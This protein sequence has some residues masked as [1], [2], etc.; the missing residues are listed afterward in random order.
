[1]PDARELALSLSLR[2]VWVMEIQLSL[3]VLEHKRNMRTLA[4]I[5]A[6]ANSKGLPGKNIRTFCGKP[7]LSWSIKAA[8]DCP[9]IDEVCVSSDGPEIL[10][11]AERASA[12][13]IKRPDHL[14]SDT[15]LPKD[16]VLHAL[17]WLKSERGTSFDV[18]VLLQPTSPLRDVSDITACVSKVIDHKFDSAATFSSMSPHPDRAWRI[19][20]HGAKPFFESESNWAPRQS[21]EPAFALNGAVYAVNVEAFRQSSSAAFLFGKNAAIVTPPERS[22][23]IDTLLDFE[24][25]EFLHRHLDRADP[26]H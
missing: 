24:I 20:D 23:D 11:C 9:E 4:V 25:A 13:P 16:A 19:E 7:L 1:M 12:I 21:L 6:R 3:S 22:F 10:A 15:A 14:A 8:H 18:V 5:P 2:R 17:D 26:A